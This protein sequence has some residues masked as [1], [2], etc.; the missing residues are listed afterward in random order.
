MSG[1]RQFQPHEL[2]HLNLIGTPSRR[3][4]S[5]AVHCG[6]LMVHTGRYR[7]CQGYRVTFGW[8]VR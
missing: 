6:I 1:L 7:E 8:W 4:Q 2:P 5:S 3:D